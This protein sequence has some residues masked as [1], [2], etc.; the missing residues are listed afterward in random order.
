MGHDRASPTWWGGT[1]PPGL[2]AGCLGIASGHGTGVALWHPGTTRPVEHDG[3]TPS[4]CPAPSANLG[5]VPEY[6]GA[7]RGQARC[8]GRKC[9]GKS[10]PGDKSPRALLSERSGSLG[11]A[12][13]HESSHEAMGGVG[14]VPHPVQG[15][16]ITSLQPSSDRPGV[17]SADCKQER[18]GGHNGFEAFLHIVERLCEALLRVTG[19]SI[20]EPGGDADEQLAVPR[21]ILGRTWRKW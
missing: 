14:L 16:G 6:V 5:Q 17:E 7:G 8:V 15:A 21:E 12:S 20:S 4:C 2:W 19:A 1:I 9:F 11:E 3:L 13:S 10:S 18:D